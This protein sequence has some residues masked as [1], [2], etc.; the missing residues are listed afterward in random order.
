MLCTP[1]CSFLCCA[2]FQRC[3]ALYVGL[4]RTIY[5]RCVYGIFGREITKYTVILRCIYTVLANPTYTPQRPLLCCA[6]NAATL[7]TL[8]CP[9]HYRVQYRL[10][11]LLHLLRCCALA[12]RLLLGGRFCCQAALPRYV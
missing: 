5:I 12:A 1:L 4:A 2:P 9:V 3:Y 10:F 11:S 8:L 7:F 6:C